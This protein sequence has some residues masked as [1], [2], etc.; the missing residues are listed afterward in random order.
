VISG[1]QKELN[2][3]LQVLSNQRAEREPMLVLDGVRRN[4]AG[5]R[6]EENGQVGNSGQVMQ[7][8]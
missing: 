2:F 7:D 1:F 6:N 8:I 3:R 5:H 4:F